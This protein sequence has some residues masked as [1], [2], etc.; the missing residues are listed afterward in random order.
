M[1][2][3]FTKKPYLLLYITFQTQDMDYNSTQRCNIVSASQIAAYYLETAFVQ[4]PC[5][6]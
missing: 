3:Y 1:F 5:P 4:S 2:I 6:K